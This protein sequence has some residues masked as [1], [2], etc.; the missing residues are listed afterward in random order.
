[1]IKLFFCQRDLGSYKF[2]QKSLYSHNKEYSVDFS[3]W[4]KKT[5]TKEERKFDMA[6]P[7]ILD[8]II[9]IDYKNN[10]HSMV[11]E[12]TFLHSTVKD[13]KEPFAYTY[14]LVHYAG[15]IK[16]TASQNSSVVFE[17]FIPYT[18]LEN[19]QY[20]ASRSDIRF[21]NFKLTDY[22]LEGEVPAKK[23]LHPQ[24]VTS[25]VRQVAY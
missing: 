25:E 8:T 17:Y 7:V 10:E 16:K 1:M 2:S 5:V 19:N 20:H 23:G 9:F 4:Q 11:L 22:L 15:N 13:A 12:Y 24:K 6:L 18:D 14:S 21:G 3:R